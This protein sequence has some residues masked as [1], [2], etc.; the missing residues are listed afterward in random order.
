MAQ[1][2]NDLQRR[3]YKLY[4]DH[5]KEHRTIRNT[6]KGFL[7]MKQRDDGLYEAVDP[8]DELNWAFW[9]P[10]QGQGKSKKTYTESSGEEEETVTQKTSYK[11]V[12]TPG[13]KPQDL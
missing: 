3:H 12:Y 7:I 1:V 13:V 8:G 6:A 10:M 5:E 4:R 2:L 11:K 9:P